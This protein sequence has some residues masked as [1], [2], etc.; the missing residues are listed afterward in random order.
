ML[1]GTN[2]PAMPMNATVFHAKVYRRISGPEGAFSNGFVHD[3]IR[4]IPVF[5]AGSLDLQIARHR[6]SWRGNHNGAVP[7]MILV[8]ND[9]IVPKSECGRDQ[10]KNKECFC[11]TSHSLKFRQQPAAS[12]GFITAAEN[13]ETFEWLQMCSPQGSEPRIFRQ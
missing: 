5:A 8:N 9:P 1:A 2:D 11:Q 6:V 10:G 7:V 3:T 4:Q 13:V 12:M